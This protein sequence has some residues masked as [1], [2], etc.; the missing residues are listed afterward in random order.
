MI[1]SI[2]AT[3]AAQTLQAV[4]KKLDPASQGRTRLEAS[5]LAYTGINLE[6]L[7]TTTLTF[8][9]KPYHASEVQ[10]LTENKR[11]IVEVKPYHA[12][13]VLSDP[14]LAFDL[15]LDE[16]EVEVLLQRYGHY[17]YSTMTLAQFVDIRDHIILKNTP[18]F[19]GNG[20]EIKSPISHF[21][22]SLVKALIERRDLH[23]EKLTAAMIVES[24]HLDRY[25]KIAHDDKTPESSRERMMAYLVSSPGYNEEDYISGSLS[26]KIY[27]HH[28]FL[29]MEIMSKISALVHPRNCPEKI[30]NRTDIPPREQFIYKMG[31]YK[32]VVA[33]IKDDT[34]HVNIVHQRKFKTAV[35]IQSA[36]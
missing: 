21:L 35:Q 3:K 5:M 30:L 6:G 13:A 16:D 22:T 24:M 19:N 8:D 32:N 15:E 14:S 20:N 31:N 27:E 11:L 36:E 2:L 25:A 1:K 29:L 10:V 17:R 7:P 18:N 12:D 23:G 28:G 26:P 34:L 33:T 4:A 9:V